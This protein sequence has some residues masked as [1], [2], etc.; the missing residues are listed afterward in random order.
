MAGLSNGFAAL[1]ENERPAV[2]VLCL[3]GAFL[4]A[5]LLKMGVAP[6]LQ[7]VR[8]RQAVQRVE[9]IFEDGPLIMSVE[10]IWA[11]GFSDPTW[12]AY[13]LKEVR[14]WAVND[15]S[16]PHGGREYKDIAEALE[17][18]QSL[19]RKHAPI[20][21]VLGM[22]QGGNLAQLLAAQ[23][24][25]EQGAAVRFTIH[26]GGCTPGW[27]HQLP[28]LF[29]EKLALPAFIVSGE[30]DR[31]DGGRADPGG[32]KMAALCRADAVVV[33]THPDGHTPF[34][35]DRP[36]AAALAEEVLD[37]ILD[38]QNFLAK[39]APLATAS[40]E[41]QLAATGT[42]QAASAE[43]VVPSST[44]HGAE[45]DTDAALAAL[46]DKISLCHLGTTLAP[47][48]LEELACTMREKGR[49][50]LLDQ[51]KGLG[52]AKLGERQGLANAI[53]KLLREQG[54]V[55]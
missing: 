41:H 29:A 42:S 32:R 46:L 5:T 4:S 21:G 52:V 26:F 51:L 16:A 8:R 6:L 10:E 30:Q 17:R 31:V 36:S 55:S 18:L 49:I 39:H 44:E 12:D 1:M 22:S 7:A 37:F 3:H 11:T 28:T 43:A 20:D 40:P 38:P 25:A 24:C 35:A 53:S 27:Q 45:G 2:R 19:L 23:A 50:Y 33:R 54:Q 13:K 34:P 15:D 9:F 14:S 48:R 47:T